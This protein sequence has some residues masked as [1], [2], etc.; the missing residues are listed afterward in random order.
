[1]L[2]SLS[3]GRTIMIHLRMAGSFSMEAGQHDRLV[4]KLSD[5]LTLYYR[6]TR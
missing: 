4:L 3:S 2:F 5:G 1:M 6:D